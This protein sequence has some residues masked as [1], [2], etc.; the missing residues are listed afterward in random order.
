MLASIMS[1]ANDPWSKFK[2]LFPSRSQPPPL[3]SAPPPLPEPPPLPRAASGMRAAAAPPPSAEAPAESR[4]QKWMSIAGQVAEAVGSALS[5]T[6]YKPMRPDPGARIY[7]PGSTVRGALPPKVDLRAHMTPIEDQGQVSSCTA[8]AVAGSYEY[9]VKRWTNQDYDVSRLFIYYN[10]RWRNGEQDKDAGSVIQLAMDGLQNFGACA[11]S[12][13]PYQKPL[14]LQ[15]PNAPSYEEGSRNVVHDTRQVPVDLQAWKQCLAEGNPIVFGALLFDSF[16]QASKRGG[17]VPMPQPSEIGRTEHGAHAM[18]AV[19]YS[20]PEGV[21]IVRNSWGPSWGDA[22]YCY[23]PYNYLMSEKLNLGDSWIFIPSAE[24]TPP[25]PTDIWGHNELPVING[26]RG[27]D[28]NPN[29]FSPRDYAKIAADPWESAVLP[30]NDAP[31]ETFERYTSL[32]EKQE[33]NKLDNFDLE[34]VPGF[35]PTN[36]GEIPW[37]DEEA[38]KNTSAED[39]WNTTGNEEAGAGEYAD[40][41]NAGVA[42]DAPS[43]G[44]SADT[45]NAG[46]GEFESAE[47]VDGS[48]GAAADA[49]PLNYEETTDQNAELID[50][51]PLNEEAADAETTNYEASTTYDETAAADESQNV[52]GAEEPA[53]ETYEEQPAEPDDDERNREA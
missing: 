37:E 29:T 9:W 33:F 38:A 26:G 27:V 40:M 6:G 28:F 51:E 42:D 46:A 43:E 4:W 24:A 53:A 19:G 21:F 15:K 3:P 20:D 48:A 32:V 10:A 12:T 22:G 31:P 36:T 13:W 25:P 39:G 5:P 44:E 50:A 18:C 45:K 17:V 30:W 34:D 16:D 2:Q 7:E 41:K 14:V 52:E 35:D 1:D 11:E 8:N 23:I 47:N 49:E